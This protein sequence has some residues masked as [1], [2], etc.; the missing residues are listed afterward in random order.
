MTIGDAEDGAMIGRVD[1]LWSDH[2]TVAEADGLA[3]YSDPQRA[4]GQLQRDA[5]L[6]EAGYEVVHFGWWEITRTPRQVAD[7]IH[8]A[9]GHAAAI[10]GRSERG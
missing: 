5:R 9:F 6:R 7:W 8:K 10:R 2:W 1:F 3:K 4:V